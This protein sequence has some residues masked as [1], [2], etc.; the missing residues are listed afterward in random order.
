MD[1]LLGQEY[2]PDEIIIVDGASSD[3]TREILEEYAQRGDIIV[4]SRPCNIAQ[5]RNLGIRAARG[6][7]IAVTD[8][9]CHL[10][11]SWLRE[12]VSCFRRNPALAVV[13]GNFRFETHTA[14][15]EAVVRG[16]FQPNRDE[17]ETAR[18]YP[19]SRSVAFTKAAWEQA[20]G[21]PEWLYTAEDTL[22]NIRLRQLGC[23]FAFCRD[24]IVRWR[25]RE[26]WGA[27]AKQRIN[28]S[29]GNAR[30]GVST[31]GYLINLR[32]H[33]VMLALILASPWYHFLL[34]LALG[35]FGWHIYKRLWSQAV[36]VTP[37]NALGM[38][39]RV[40]AVMEFVRIVNLY[41]FLRG[42][43]DR[44][45]DPSYIDNIQRYM[46]VASVDELDFLHTRPQYRVKNL[47]LPLDRE[48]ISL[49]ALALCTTGCGVVAW[50]ASS[51]AR[52]DGALPAIA[53]AAAGAFALLAKSLVNYSQTGPS[54]HADI[55][56]HYRRYTLLAMGRLGFWAFALLLFIGSGGVSS[57]HAMTA[58]FGWVWSSNSRCWPRS[59]YH[60][61]QF[62][63]V[64]PKLR[65]N[66]TVGWLNAIPDGRLYPPGRLPRRA[67]FESLK[68]RSDH[69]GAPV[70]QRVVAT[71]S[72]GP[73]GGT[74]SARVVVDVLLWRHRLLRMVT[75]ARAEWAPRERAGTARPTSCLSGPTRCAPIASARLAIV[76]RSRQTSTP[77]GR[78]AR[79]SGTATSVRAN[80]A[81]PLSMLR[82]PGR[83]P[84]AS[85]TISSQTPRRASASRR[86]RNC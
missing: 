82:E 19:S 58:S 51:H 75:G 27:L 62:V 68:A 63:P 44:L 4:I 25:P 32:S 18:Y 56:A 31:P 14:F 67:V 76:V 8:A 12:I 49:I 53:V 39:L 7:H 69:L 40:L 50:L 73:S 78:R 5:G 72:A 70:C 43:F 22:F 38:R 29:R 28:F 34:L 84:T 80:R 15:E 64:R 41:G 37:D 66:R 83:T 45:S 20:G 54:I 59:W 10:D 26:T 85:A 86:C 55:L 6:S 9:G 24:A 16:T 65:Y 3:G 13:A 21:Y 81:E 42:R 77:S 48:T 46:G 30:I 57:T 11:S 1:S 52:L 36:A 71:G 74:G 47:S 79:S 2:K 35:L 17:T 60:R 23:E 33:G 61:R